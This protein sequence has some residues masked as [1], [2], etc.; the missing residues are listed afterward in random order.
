[1]KKFILTIA[2]LAIALA[3]CSGSTDV[4]DSTPTPS[5]SESSGSV[6]A[7]PEPSP[8]QTESSS[9]E[10]FLANPDEFLNSS[11]SER[12]DMFVT[13][14]HA[15]L[16]ESGLES[17]YADAALLSAGYGYCEQLDDGDE[18][19][20]IFEDLMTAAVE[21]NFAED[22]EKV[23]QVGTDVTILASSLALCP[24]HIDE[25]LTPD[26]DTSSS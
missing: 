15:V 14:V 22:E 23:I 19:D 16:A 26:D 11:E 5:V 1:M 4:T 10:E 13:H 3:G 9:V 24:E 25:A 8:S 2:P 18:F 17:I 21:D 6:V 7:T 12:E 20:G